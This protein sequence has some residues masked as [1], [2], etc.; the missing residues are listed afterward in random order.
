[1]LH[2]VVDIV[3]KLLNFI[4]HNG[5]LFVHL[6][7]RATFV[8][9]IYGYATIVS[10]SIVVAMASHALNNLVGGILWRYTSKSAPE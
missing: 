10:K 1:M 6:F 8:G 7:S 2:C 9:L 4:L 3:L 5:D